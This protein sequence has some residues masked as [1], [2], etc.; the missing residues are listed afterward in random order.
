MSWQDDCQGETWYTCNSNILLKQAEE[1]IFRNKYPYILQPI[2]VL[3]HS[4]NNLPMFKFP[5]GTIR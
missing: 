1:R 2:N 3:M 5:N 4:G